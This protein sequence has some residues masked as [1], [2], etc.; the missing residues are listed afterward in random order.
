MPVR[1]RDFVDVDGHIKWPKKGDGF[2]LDDSGNPITEPA[3]LKAGQFIDRYGNS[4]GRF[5]SPLEN[6]QK[7]PFESRGL[8]YPE[9]YQ[10]YHKYEMVKD[11]NIE[12]VKLGFSTL[13]SADRQ[14]LSAEME[15]YGKNLNDLANPKIGDIAK[16]FGQGGGKQ[17]QFETSVKWYEKMGL[18]KEID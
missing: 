4:G 14:L 10:P 15:R 3:N 8:P 1:S 5:T 6:G 11:I 16:V 9:G 18:L 17:I 7:L 12:N 13:S 2:V